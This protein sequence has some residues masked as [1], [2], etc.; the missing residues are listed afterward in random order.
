MLLSTARGTEQ[1][2]G[3]GVVN[4]QSGFSGGSDPVSIKIPN[5]GIYCQSYNEV[6][7]YLMY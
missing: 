4:V 7:N 1:G 3:S 6:M 2:S 5:P